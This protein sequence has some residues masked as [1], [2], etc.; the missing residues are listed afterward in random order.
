M[1]AKTR[2]IRVVNDNSK[3]GWVN[4]YWFEK[5]LLNNKEKLIKDGKLITFTIPKKTSLTVD[6]LIRML[7]Y[8]NQLQDNGYKIKLD[9]LNEDSP[10]MGYLDRLGFFQRLHGKVKVKPKPPEI[11]G[12]QKYHGTNGTLV[13]LAVV[14]SV[15]E[16]SADLSDRLSNAIITFLKKER[17]NLSAANIL[18]L[19]TIYKTIFYE[20][21]NNIHEH[22][23]T[24]LD[25]LVGLQAYGGTTPRIEIVVCDSGV[26]LLETIKDSLQTH[27]AKYSAFSDLMLVKEMFNEGISSKNPEEYA[28]S[29]LKTCFTQAKKMGSGLTIRINKSQFSIREMDIENDDIGQLRFMD[30]LLPVSGTFICFSIPVFLS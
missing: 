9:F 24:Q 8:V 16:P 7:S 17:P 6:G 13:E 20:L 15:E 3:S 1:A 26:G 19:D 14:N 23:K 22:S 11:S 28:G 12:S 4:G 2:N 30:E 27:N 25:G 29:G 18:R 10:A 5:V 21:I